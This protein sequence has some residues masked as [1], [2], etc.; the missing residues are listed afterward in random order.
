M[1]HILA[2]HYSRHFHLLNLVSNQPNVPREKPSLTQRYKLPGCE[3]T[4]LNTHQCPQP[5][6]RHNKIT[7]RCDCQEAHFC[8]RLPLNKPLAAS[9][10]LVLQICLPLCLPSSGLRAHDSSASSALCQCS[11]ESS[12]AAAAATAGISTLLGIDIASASANQDTHPA[13]TK[14]P[15]GESQR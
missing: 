5:H 14:S 3:D 7:I 10:L 1:E 9:S 11:A 2:G 12:A 8:C 6:P 15:C 4:L 13:I